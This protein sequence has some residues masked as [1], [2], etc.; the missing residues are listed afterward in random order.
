[1]SKLTSISRSRFENRS[2]PARD[3]KSARTTSSAKARRDD[4]AG[5]AASGPISARWLMCET[6]RAHG[7]RSTTQRR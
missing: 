3:V 4:P 1:L 2:N 6:I 7:L 5:P